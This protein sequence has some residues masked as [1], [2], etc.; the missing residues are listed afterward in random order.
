MYTKFQLLIH[1]LI[2]IYN[3]ITGR[4][5]SRRS[6]WID[7][8]AI[9]PK[10]CV[11]GERVKIKDKVILGEYCLVNDMAYIG[12]IVTIGKGC[13]IEVGVKIGSCNT[14][15]KGKIRNPPLF[16]TNRWVAGEEDIPIKISKYVVMESNCMVDKGVTIGEKAVI[17]SGAVVIED[18]PAF[19][20]VQGNP[21]K[22]I[23][24]RV[25]KNSK[26]AGEVNMELSEKG[27]S[28]RHGEQT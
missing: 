24:Y 23:G 16:P 2:L 27:K 26:E 15:G 18:V 3:K 20:I 6:A 4:S 22:I 19:A 7:P 9:V 12:G 8:L 21:A 5:H 1:K 14:D 28:F 25:E 13:R 10:T 11:I 17:R